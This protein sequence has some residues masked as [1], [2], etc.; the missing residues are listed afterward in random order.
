MKNDFKVNLL[1]YSFKSSLDPHQI[2]CSGIVAASL[3]VSS[4]VSRLNLF[5]NWL[6]QHILCRCVL[7]HCYFMHAGL[8]LF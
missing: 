5:N 3:I 6:L 1:V 7:F 2:K 8:D 4:G